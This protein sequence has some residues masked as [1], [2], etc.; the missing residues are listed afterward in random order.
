MSK[1]EEEDKAIALE[2]MIKSEITLNSEIN[3]VFQK[4]SEKLLVIKKEF[5]QNQIDL[6]ERIRQY[7]ELIG[8]IKE[9]S[10]EAGRLGLDM[11]EYGIYLISSDYVGD[12]NSP[13]LINLSHDISSRLTGLLDGGWQ[14]SSKREE[15]IKTVKQI[16]QEVVLKNYRGKIQIQ[17]FPKFLNRL[18]D[19]VVKRF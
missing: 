17:D 8:E 3:P 1:D 2:K 14:D 15:F 10:G 16:V 11:R 9:K 7:Y 19:V 13:E 4:F 18:V 12:P 5:E 6:A